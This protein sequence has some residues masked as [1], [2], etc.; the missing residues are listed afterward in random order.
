MILA[1]PGLRLCVQCVVSTIPKGS[2]SDVSAN[3]E[4]GH[5]VVTDALNTRPI[6]NLSPWVTAYSSVRFRH[7]Q[8]WRDSWTT[9]C[10]TSARPK[11]NIYDNAFPLAL[12]AEFARVSNLALAGVTIDRAKFFDMMQFC[13]GHDLVLNLGAH[14]GV[15]CAAR[16]LHSSLDCRYRVGRAISRAFKGKEDL[17]RVTATVSKCEF[18]V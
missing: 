3:V 11:R 18:Q 15:V 10:M 2:A 8:K 7:M 14:E 16:N 5:V 1:A 4:P 6:A 12:R 17:C 9:P 13:L